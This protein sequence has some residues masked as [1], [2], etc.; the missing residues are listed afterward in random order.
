MHAGN[1]QHKFVLLC[2]CNGDNP[3]YTGLPGRLYTRESILDHHAKL[4]YHS[5]PLRGTQVDIGIGLAF[6]RP[7]VIDDPLR[8]KP[9]VEPELTDKKVE[10]RPPRSRGDR[11]G[12]MMFGNKIEQFVDSRRQ[13]EVHIVFEAKCTVNLLF[14]LDQAPL[15]DQIDLA[16]QQILE[17]RFTVPPV[18]MF[19]HLFRIERMAAQA[20]RHG[21]P[22][23]LLL[24][25]IEK[26][27][28]VEIE[29]NTVTT[30]FHAVTS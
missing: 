25:G 6:E 28:T 10:I 7:V 13:M 26:E 19:V 1:T 3:A 14:L 30:Q 20:E 24:F 9:T 21:I 22:R 17:N 16:A 15:F 18:Y 4:G 29:N 5:D 11:R 8:L 27:R 2:R 23:L 12:N